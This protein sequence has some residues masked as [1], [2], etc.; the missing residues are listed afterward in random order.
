MVS[1]QP[2][3]FDRICHRAHRSRAAALGPSTFLID[4]VA[5]D[6]CDRLAAVLRR[7]E[8]ALDVGTPTD[9]VRRVLAASGKVGT[10]IA[11][12][13]LAGTAAFRHLSDSR[14]KGETQLCIAADEEA[15]PLRD[16]SLDLVVSALALQF[17]NDLPGALIQIRRALRPDGLF[18]A[19]LAGGETLTELRQTFAAAEAEIEDGISPRVAPF[20]DVR[21]MGALLQ[22]A[23]FA[24]PVTDVDRLTARYDSPISLMHDLRRMGA[25]NA[26]VERSRRP[27]KRATL[28]RMSEIYAERFADRDGRIRATFEIIWLSG[29]APHASQQKPL[30]P[31]SARRRL[32]DALGTKE[33]RLP[34][35]GER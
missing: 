31:G 33:T 11:A 10:I 26:L 14:G 32:A 7:F 19:A 28:T 24:L 25:T 6:L 1:S 4:R 27:L 9:A 16:A 15:L 13:A 23:G 21:D 2:V 35:D 8:F 34:R 5:E 22:R 30:A 18:L 17:V 12:D 20:S 3:I 29:W